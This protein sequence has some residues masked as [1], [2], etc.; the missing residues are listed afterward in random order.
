MEEESMYCL[1]RPEFHFHFSYEHAS[2]ALK[3]GLRK[4]SGANQ[5]ETGSNA[6]PDCS[7]SM[8][9]GRVSR[10]FDFTRKDIRMKNF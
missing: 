1:V 4:L 10:L 5:S 3:V 6:E 9:D 8:D 7:Y 2:P